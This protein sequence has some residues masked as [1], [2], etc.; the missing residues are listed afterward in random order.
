MRLVKTK[1]IQALLLLDQVSQSLTGMKI[2]HKE[3]PQPLC[4]HSIIKNALN[5]VTVPS[6]IR[7]HIKV[8]QNLPKVLGGEQQLIGIFYHLIQNAVD[9]MPNG[10]TLSIN[11]RTVEADEKLWVEVQ[12]CDTGVGITLE[13]FDEIFQLGFTTKGVKEI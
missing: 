7:T 8:A 1:E 9:A 6:I 4:I 11:A 13:K 2:A 5:E 10:G 3:K 12:V